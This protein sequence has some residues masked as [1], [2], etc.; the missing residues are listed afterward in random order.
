MTLLRSRCCFGRA[1]PS[2]STCHMVLILERLLKAEADRQLDRD[3]TV[4][5]REDTNNDITKLCG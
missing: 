1:G 3:S 4:L 5:S 2:G